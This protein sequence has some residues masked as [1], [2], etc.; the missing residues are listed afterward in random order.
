MAE[1]SIFSPPMRPHSLDVCASPIDTTSPRADT[2][3][4]TADH[5][6]TLRAAASHLLHSVRGAGRTVAE[7]AA[8][9]AQPFARD[10]HTSDEEE[11]SPDF[12]EAFSTDDTDSED[13]ARYQRAR[14]GSGSAAG[15]AA[16]SDYNSD[17]ES[18]PADKPAEFDQQQVV[19]NSPAFSF[20]RRLQ[21]RKRMPSYAHLFPPADAEMP[22]QPIESHG[23]IGNC[24][25]TALVSLEG[26]VVWYCYPNHNSPSI[27]HSLIDQRSGRAG[28]GPGPCFRITPGREEGATSPTT[29]QLY[30]TETN[31][32]LTR[33][34]TDSGVGHVTDYMCMGDASLE[35]GAKHWLVRELEVVRGKMYFEVECAPAF[36]YGRATHTTE[37]L[38][39]GALFTSAGAG[40]A[41]LVTSSKARV[42]KSTPNGGART[43]V[44]LQEGQRVV[45]VFREWCE[46]KE[47][48][49]W[50]ETCVQE[51]LVERQRVYL[52]E[53]LERLDLPTAISTA[54][55]SAAGTPAPG[56]PTSA[57]RTMSPVKIPFARTLS[58]DHAN[59]PSPFASRS[60]APP[61]NPPMGVPL[62]LLRVPSIDAAITTG[63]PS[64]ARSVAASEASSGM[65]TPHRDFDATFGTHSIR[66]ISISVTDRLRRETTE[67]VQT[68]YTSAQPCDTRHDLT[69]DPPSSLL[70]AGSGASGCRSALTRVDGARACDDQHSCSSCSHSSQPVRSSRRRLAVSES[71]QRRT[72]RVWS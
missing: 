61:I 51:E 59:T 55:T 6:S 29:K 57:R 41:M 34:F 72:E 42:W 56:T 33:F 28:G 53:Q 70:S 17:A 39:H 66:P 15:L 38:P 9:L 16:H 68:M 7:L 3:S 45:F 4:S 58:D 60:S 65:Q 50:S 19:R 24:H 22:P 8:V 67:S 20:A 69:C 47:R 10:A 14:R 23:L 31:V 12:R 62:A 1:K 30:Y 35:H 63:P 71:T 37:I 11:S 52:Q 25:T 48:A 36:D 13:E 2:P 46:E 40:L 26:S 18:V 44:K 27:F 43:K 21:L 54:P 64:A 32:L 49:K 5:E